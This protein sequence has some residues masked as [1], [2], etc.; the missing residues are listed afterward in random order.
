MDL[1]GLIKIAPFGKSNY[2]MLFIDDFSPKTWIYFLKENL[3][4]FEAFK[5]FKEIMK[6]LSGHKIKALLSDHD[7]EYIDDTFKNF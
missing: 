6:N 1:C 7:S 2:F 3:D 4:A 5:N